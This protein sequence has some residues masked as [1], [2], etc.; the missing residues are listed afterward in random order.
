MRGVDR[1]RGF[2]QVGRGS[3]GPR[4]ALDTRASPAGSRAVHSVRQTSAPDPRLCGKASVSIHR[5]PRGSRT[6]PMDFHTSVMMRWAMAS[7]ETESRFESSQDAGMSI[8][9]AHASDRPWAAV[10]TGA[11]DRDNGPPRGAYPVSDLT[12]R[13]RSRRRLGPSN[14]SNCPELHL[15]SNSV[16]HVSGVVNP[17]R[18]AEYMSSTTLLR[19]AEHRA[20]IQPA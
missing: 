17:S 9:P 11:T 18:P 14:A 1:S 20:P 15:T 12:A 13:A 3:R 2:G 6:R 7:V 16:V 8:S 19:P 4:A 5:A 10:T